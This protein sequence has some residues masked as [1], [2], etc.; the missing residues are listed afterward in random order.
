MVNDHW[1]TRDN[2]ARVIS[3]GTSPM[4]KVGS[5]G[6]SKQLDGKV[7]HLDDMAKQRIGKLQHEM[8]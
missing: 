6:L 1:T 8:A 2:M 4:E 5:V 7:S 3:S